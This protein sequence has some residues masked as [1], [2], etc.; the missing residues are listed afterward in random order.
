MTWDE[1]TQHWKNVAGD[2]ERPGLKFGQFDARAHALDHWA[3][4][5]LLPGPGTLTPRRSPSVPWSGN[6]NSQG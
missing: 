5:Q 4:P 1:V 6:P 3:T 2:H